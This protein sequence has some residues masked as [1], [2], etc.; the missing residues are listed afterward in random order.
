MSHPLLDLQAP[1]V[2]SVFKNSYLD[3]RE[4]FQQTLADIP[5]SLIK[6]SERFVHPLTGPAGEELACETVLLSQSEQPETILVVI[7]G[8]HGVEGVTGSA[9]QADILPLLVDVLQKSARLGV[10]L[11]HAMNP[12]GFAWVRRGDHQGIDL[13]RNFI[14]FDQPVPMNEDYAQYQSQLHEARWLEVSDFSGLWQG[15]SFADFIEQITRGQYQ[16][17]TGLFY[18]GN[19]PSWSRQVL[20]TITRHAVFES[21][22][23]INV[24]DCHTGLGPYGYGEVIND[25]FPNT[26]GFDWVNRLYG[27][28]ACAALLGESCSAPK[29]GLIDYHWQKVIGGRGCFV[30]LEFGTYSV[31]KLISELLREQIYQNTLPQGVERNIKAEPV[32]LMQAFFYPRESSW[33][34]QVLFRGRQVVN[35]A[36]QGVLGSEQ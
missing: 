15:V 35:M 12:W 1:M 32:R 36:L 16:D 3:A 33:Q 26:A 29:S 34:Q 8:T 11:I 14:D 5:Q 30:T 31:D 18:G 21:A 22:H 7:S 19:A 4:C 2:L 25:H 28:N 10:M 27:A 13:N 9:I 20:E 24:I 6:Q 17:P 23:N